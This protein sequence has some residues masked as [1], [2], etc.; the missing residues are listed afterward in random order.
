MNHKSIKLLQKKE[1]GKK[2]ENIQDLRLGKELLDLTPKVQSIKGKADKLDLIKI[3]N[4]CSVK[5]SL[6]KM[7]RQGENWEKISANHI[8]N[9]GLHSWAFIPEK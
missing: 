8:S 2:G 7:K 5:G 9:K 4:L 3:K 1:R 6:K